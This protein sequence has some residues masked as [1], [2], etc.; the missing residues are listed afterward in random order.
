MK[1]FGY[2]KVIKFESQ[3]QKT[4]VQLLIKIMYSLNKMSNNQKI[5]DPEKN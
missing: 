2:K 3:N 1:P 5:E 4:C